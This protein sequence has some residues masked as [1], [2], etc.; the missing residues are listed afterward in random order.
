MYTLKE[1]PRRLD[2]VVI[3]FFFFLF[4]FTIRW[5]CTFNHCAWGVKW[6]DDHQQYEAHVGI[7][8]VRSADYGDALARAMV[9]FI[10]DR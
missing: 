3:W 5:W 7:Y 1:A 2:A 10:K 6:L 4:P 9:W 8:N